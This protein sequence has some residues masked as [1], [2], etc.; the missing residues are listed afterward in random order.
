VRWICP[1]C[2]S[3]ISFGLDEC[4]FCPPPGKAAPAKERPAAPPPPP[5]RAAARA[6]LTLASEEERGVWLSR[7]VR[8]VLG[9]L[10]AVSLIF[11]LLTLLL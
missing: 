11:L 5:V 2:G 6:P 7:G 3:A 1:R 9:L 8:L 4:P 10:L